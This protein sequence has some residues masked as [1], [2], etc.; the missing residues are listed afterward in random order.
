MNITIRY[1]C[2]SIKRKQL[3][4]ELLVPGICSRQYNSDE[5]GIKGKVILLQT[6]RILE[7]ELKFPKFCRLGIR[8]SDLKG[9]RFKKKSGQDCSRKVE[10]H[11]KQELE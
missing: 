9:F 6:V 3:I 8:D 2:Q 5:T 4:S 11:G 7:S 1:Q 10:C